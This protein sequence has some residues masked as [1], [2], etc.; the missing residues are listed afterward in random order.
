VTAAREIRAVVFDFDGLV[1]DT[2]FPVY[3]AWCEAFESHGAA[4]PTIEEWSAEIGTAGAIDL[5]AWLLEL[6]TVPVD[7]DAMHDRRRSLRD[8]L[9]ASEVARPGVAA[10]LDEAD[11]AGLDLAIASSSPADWV[12]PLLDRLGLRDRFRWIVNA[13]GPLR[14]KPAPDTYLE[15][16]ARLGVEPRDALA[17]EDSPHGIAAAKD[18]GLSCVAVPHGL[19]DTLDLSA[20]DLRVRS[21]ADCTLAEALV[22]LTRRTG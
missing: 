4:P 12:L 5:E 3:A 11:A 2:E 17:V 6:A 15:A 7:I 10:W 22:R 14:G 13:E 9:L 16:C 18:A 19:T 21:L 1:L 8:E 20:A